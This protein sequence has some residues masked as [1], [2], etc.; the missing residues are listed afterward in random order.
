MPNSVRTI[1]ILTSHPGKVDD[2]RMLLEGLVNPSRSEAGNLHYD[3]LQDRSDPG[4]FVLDELYEDDHA[5]ERHHA[6]DHFQNYLSRISELA[7][8]NL[9]I[10]EP[11]KISRRSDG[12]YVEDSINAASPISFLAGFGRRESG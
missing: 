2:L 8:R 12:S 6:T 11:I 7:A 9:M 10:V 5:L 4:R 1:A 3:L